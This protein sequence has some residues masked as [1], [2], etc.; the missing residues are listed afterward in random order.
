MRL[1]RGRKLLPAAVPR[2]RATTHHSA[3]RALRA[4]SDVVGDGLEFESERAVVG[5]MGGIR[6]VDGLA[7]DAFDEEFKNRRPVLFTA[8]CPPNTGP[9]LFGSGRY[10]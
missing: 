2:C 8:R 6:F 10:K 4:T 7:A 5:F 9:D 1:S 3:T